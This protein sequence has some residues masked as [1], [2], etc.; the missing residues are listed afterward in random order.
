[1]YFDGS[2][3]DRLVSLACLAADE[4]VWKYFEQEWAKILADRG[5]AK[6][7]HM[8]EA[9]PLEDHFKDW[10]PDDRDSLV[11]GLTGLLMEVGRHRRF[12]SFTCTVDMEAHARWRVRNRLPAPARLCARVVFPAVIN[13]YGEFPDIVLDSIDV[14][15]DRNEPFIGHISADWNSKKIRQKFQV[16]HLVRTIAPA[17]MK[18]TP[19]LQAADMLAWATHRLTR[20]I[21]PTSN[22]IVV[23]RTYS[24][25]DRSDRFLSLATDIFASSGES[26]GAAGFPEIREA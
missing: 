10:R 23:S 22:D 14:F 7:M 1:M 8:K 13:W 6:Y 3:N 21:C 19:P 16:W 25:T 9:M 15:F 24:L 18:L 4:D 2:W 20:K 12:H 11:Q 5:G 17:E 26:V